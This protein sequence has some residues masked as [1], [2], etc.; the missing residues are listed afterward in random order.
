MRPFH[1]AVLVLS[2]ALTPWLG[3]CDGNTEPGPDPEVRVVAASPTSLTGTAGAEVQPVPAVR[4]TDEQDRPLAGVAIT[5]KVATGGG[6]VSGGSVTSG[7]DGL[8]ALAKWTLGQAAGT[9]T[10]R[11]SASGANDLVFTALALMAQPLNPL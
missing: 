6:T 5:L 1:T 3:G 4:I 7:T 10:L 2:A 11:A 9:Q 8:A